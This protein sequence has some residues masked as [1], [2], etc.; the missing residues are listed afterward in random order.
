[1]PCICT[2]LPGCVIAANKEIK[3]ACC[4]LVKDIVDYV[5]REKAQ[6][7]GQTIGRSSE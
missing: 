6:P 1:V 5:G 3:F 7:G 4:P 2:L